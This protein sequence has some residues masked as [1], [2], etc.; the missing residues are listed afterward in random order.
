M[1]GNKVR[2]I[3]FIT[4]ALIATFSFLLWFGIGHFVAWLLDEGLNVGV[5]KGVFVKAGIIV[6]S[7]KALVVIVIGTIQNMMM[8]KN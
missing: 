8:K 4:V 2:L 7:I 5:N 3:H 1:G 6:G